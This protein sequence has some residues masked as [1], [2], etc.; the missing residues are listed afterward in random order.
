MVTADLH[1]H[2]NFCD[3]KSGIEEIII[4]AINKGL[5]AV[6]ISSHGYTEFD[7]SY[8]IKAEK[9]AEYLKE[10][11]TL[12]DKYKDKIKV[13][14]GVEHDLFSCNPT[15]KYDYVIGSMH[16]VKA[17]DKYY[18]LDV[19]PEGFNSIVNNVFGGDT[20]ALAEQYF[21]E[22][23]TALQ[24]KKVDIIG[25]FDLITK[26]NEDGT[27]FDTKHPRYIAAYKKAIDGVIS[28]G[29]PFEINTG[30]ISRGYRTQPYPSLDIIE[31]IR[32]KGGK[33]ILSS[34][35]H[36]SD[37]VAYQLNEWAEKLKPLSLEILN[38]K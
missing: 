25:H 11:E 31:Y 32:D 17:G 1:I 2:T 38:V 13:F 35:S 5:S 19:N 12:R 29:V 10:I 26:Y 6:G 30:A 36:S 27:L 23:S 18:S 24:N 20:Y 34:D 7:T 28:L 37:T 22:F 21:S 9:I 14:A 8:C 15:D 16:Y 3:G 4:S 33:F